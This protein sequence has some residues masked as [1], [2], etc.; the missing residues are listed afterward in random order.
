MAGIFSRSS[1]S[2]FCIARKH[3]SELNW[4]WLQN[5]FQTLDLIDFNFCLLIRNGLLIPKKSLSDCKVNGNVCFF[6]KNWTAFSCKWARLLCSCRFAFPMHLT[7][8]QE[9]TLIC[10]KARVP[11]LWKHK[12]FLRIVQCV[13]VA[14]LLA[15]WKLCQYL[16]FC[17]LTAKNEPKMLFWMLWNPHSPT[18]LCLLRILSLPVGL[19]TSGWKPGSG[20]SAAAAAAAAWD[21]TFLPLQ[22]RRVALNPIVS[23]KNTV[24]SPVSCLIFSVLSCASF[25]N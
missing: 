19:L 3:T 1:L 12:T 10:C 6:K 5:N 13:D 2:V 22:C 21:P 11:T 18:T 8:E 24:L 20:A 7:T 9:R 25:C 23:N 4:K 14:L 16:M 17:V 15:V